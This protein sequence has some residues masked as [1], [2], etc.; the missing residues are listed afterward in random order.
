MEKLILQDKATIGALAD[1]LRHAL[2]RAT[3]TERLVL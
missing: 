1:A 3:A 2:S